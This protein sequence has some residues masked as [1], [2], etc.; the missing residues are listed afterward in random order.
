MRFPRISN[1]F[2]H[3]MRNLMMERLRT[4]AWWSGIA[5]CGVG[6]AAIGMRDDHPQPPHPRT[7][8]RQETPEMQH[9]SELLH[10]LPQSEAEW[11]SRL[12]AEQFRILRQQGTERAFSGKYA[13]S[14]EQGIYR[15]AGCGQTLFHSEHKFDSGTGWP[16]FWQPIDE[17]H[18]AELADNSLFMRRIEVRCSRCDGH[19]G[20]VFDDGP[21]PT[22]LRYCM[23]SA[24]LM[25]D[26]AN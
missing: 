20:H 18:V 7:D 12:T 23:N 1:T 24:A 3:L 13:N 26:P 10:P 19:L 22:G 25:L 15:C 16:S 8:N 9:D 6:L 14:H 5:A 4:L 2:I 11:K 17:S 21:E